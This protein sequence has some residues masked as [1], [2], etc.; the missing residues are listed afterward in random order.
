M[1][2]AGPHSNLDRP[3]TATRLL[4]INRLVCRGETRVVEV[5]GVRMTV[6]F[7]GRKGHRG[8]IAIAAPPGATFRTF[9]P[10]ESNV[11]RTLE[12]LE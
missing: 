8:R 4:R 9:E 3:T 6:R 2:E 7:I 10:K 11:D 5:A 1:H 12:L